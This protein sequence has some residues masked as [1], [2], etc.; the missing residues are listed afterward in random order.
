MAHE[1]EIVPAKPGRVLDGHDVGRRLDNA[2]L[3][4]IPAAGRADRT[5]LVLGKHP[6]SAAVPDSFDR[7]GQRRRQAL[8]ALAIALQQVKR[9]A[10]RRLLPDAGHAAQAIDQANQQG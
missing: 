5:Q 10:L 1:H 9:D 2:E 8:G 3:R 7:I 6:A 4:C